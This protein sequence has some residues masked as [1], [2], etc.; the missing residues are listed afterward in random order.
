[1]DI[2]SQKIVDFEWCKTCAHYSDPEYCDTCNTCLN[3]PMNT[4]SHKPINYKGRNI[5]KGENN[6][7]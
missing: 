3:E 4:Y 5:V 7:K 2:Y 1:M 6:V